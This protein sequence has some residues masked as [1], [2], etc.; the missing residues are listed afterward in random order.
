VL[1]PLYPPPPPP[2]QQ[3]QQPV[4]RASGNATAQCSAWGRH[5]HSRSAVEFHTFAP[6]EALACVRPT[7]C[8][9]GVHYAHHIAAA[10]CVEP[11]KAQWVKASGMGY[12]MLNSAWYISAGHYNV[13]I[14]PPGY[15]ATFSDQT[16]GMESGVRFHAFAP[17]EPLPCVRPMPFLSDRR[18]LLLV[19][20]AISTET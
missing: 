18:C 7:A 16:F 1:F 17:R 10:H 19:D 11:L 3:Q 5:L 12:V 15:G 13:S 4:Q 14:G 8:L 20:A 6:L 9:S 2:P